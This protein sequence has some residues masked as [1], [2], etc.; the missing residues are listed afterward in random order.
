MNHA[1]SIFRAYIAARER[2]GIPSAIQITTSG[3]RSE[4]CHAVLLRGT[5]GQTL[6]G[7][8]LRPAAAEEYHEPRETRHP[9]PKAEQDRMA[10]AAD[11]FLPLQSTIET[12]PPALEPRDWFLG[13]SAEL[14]GFGRILIGWYLYLHP[15]VSSRSQASGIAHEIA[16]H[17][18]E[19]GGWSPWRI[20]EDVRYAR[21]IVAARAQLIEVSVRGCA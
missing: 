4:C 17:L 10:A 2:R 7:K 3:T 8:C 20:R 14:W 15:K 9:S 16:P 18:A 1:D 11:R 13:H 19:P 21:T 12:I 5:K 6:C